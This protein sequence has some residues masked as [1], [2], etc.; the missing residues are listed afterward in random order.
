M[1]LKRN[2][3]AYQKFHLRVLF[4]EMIFHVLKRSELASRY[5]RLILQS[6]RPLTPFGSHHHADIYQLGFDPLNEGSL[7]RMRKSAIVSTQGNV[8]S[9]FFHT[10]GGFIHRSLTVS[11]RNDALQFALEYRDFLMSRK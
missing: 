9:R 11:E 2:L 3:V 10:D 8:S 4:F 5:S 1:F 7:C 6:V